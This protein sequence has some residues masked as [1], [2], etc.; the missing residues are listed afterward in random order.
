MGA[1][2]QQNQSGPR[3]NVF[4]QHFPFTDIENSRQN[5]VGRAAKP[6]PQIGSLVTKRTQR[7]SNLDEISDV[8][9]IAPAGRL[10]GDQRS[11]GVL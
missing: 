4:N 10:A 9:G 2:A 11:W 1:S 6:H 8:A 7:V 5:L 3:P